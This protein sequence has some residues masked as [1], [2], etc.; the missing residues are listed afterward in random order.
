MDKEQINS[1]EERIKNIKKLVIKS[2]L[3]VIIGS[4]LITTIK[5]QS[6]GTFIK[7]NSSSPVF[8]PNLKFSST[9]AEESYKRLLETINHNQADNETAINDLLNCIDTM[10]RTLENN[11]IEEVIKS[12]FDNISLQNKF[13]ISI[14]V[15]LAE[16]NK[17]IS[18]DEI[19][20]L[21]GSGYSLS[22]DEGV[23]ITQYSY[24]MTLI[25]HHLFPN[26]TDA[27]IGKL[28][29]L[30]KIIYDTDG[31]IREYFR[32]ESQ[33]IIRDVESRV[34]K[35]I[36]DFYEG[37]DN[38]SEREQF[39]FCSGLSV[40]NLDVENPAA[41]NSA[42]TGMPVDYAGLMS[43]YRNPEMVQLI[44]RENQDKLTRTDNYIKNEMKN[45]ASQYFGWG[46]TQYGHLTD[47][48][49]DMFNIGRL[50]A[51]FNKTI[52]RDKNII[53]KCKKVLNDK[54]AGQPTEVLETK[55][56]PY[57]YRL[58]KKSHQKELRYYLL[59]DTQLSVVNVQPSS[60][61]NL[62]MTGETYKKSDNIPLIFKWKEKNANCEELE[63][64]VKEILSKNNFEIVENGLS[65]SK[66]TKISEVKLSVQ[67]KSLKLGKVLI[68]SIE[69][70][71]IFSNSIDFIVNDSENLIQ[72]LQSKDIN[73]I[74]S[75]LSSPT[76]LDE[77]KI[78]GEHPVAHFIKDDMAFAQEL[79]KLGASPDV[80]D[81][82][83]RTPLMYAV[84]RQDNEFLDLLLNKNV[85]LNEL[86]KKGRTAIMYA[87]IKNNIYAAKK[88]VE[89]KAN[90]YKSK[91]KGWSA[92]RY[93]KELGYKDI[94]K[95]LN[96]SNFDELIIFSDKCDTCQQRKKIFKKIVEHY[97]SLKIKYLPSSTIGQY[98]PEGGYYNPVIL[99]RN[100][101]NGKGQYSTGWDGTEKSLQK[102]MNGE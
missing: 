65:C 100:S 85:N 41:L 57:V 68:P 22:T 31:S 81:K 42:N 5:Y 23:R 73:A 30:G 90:M 16:Q 58:L 98:L 78:D 12:V 94:E 74:K 52:R 99:I 51:Y 11:E 21:L 83:G 89:H 38:K 70:Y 77:I 28:S 66:D 15:S 39:Y 43:I 13:L 61:I 45:R 87:A 40:A 91:D 64:K 7:N 17:N 36:D 35:K 6:N 102:L 32:N 26:T 2:L 88:L 47:A 44:M 95:L 14:G 62:E 53:S 24:K 69:L 101:T 4:L 93:A 33:K 9:K 20:P 71:D 1:Q 55:G 86:D 49:L 8:S 75:S 48:E 46:T 19:V 56:S 37:L 63:T 92:Y 60:Y 50:T 10:R 59:P 18:A 84:I 79:I 25:A 97:T 3:V 96:N 72:A 27:Q 29:A 34:A 54:M 82:D 76:D 80:I 67:V